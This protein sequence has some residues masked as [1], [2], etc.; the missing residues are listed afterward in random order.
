MV[1]VKASLHEL[2]DLLTEL[3]TLLKNPDLGSALAARGVNVS[4]ALV[5]T[6]G[7]RAYLQGDKARAAEEFDTLAEEIKTRLEASKELAKGKPS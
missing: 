3:E 6:E 7:L 1:D 5:G 2:E 4:L